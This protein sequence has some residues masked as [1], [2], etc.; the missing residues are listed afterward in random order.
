MK[1]LVALVLVLAPAIGIAGTPPPIDASLPVA[2]VAATTVEG[3]WQ[4]ALA[5]GST[6]L[7]LVV[8][9]RRTSA[10]WT[11]TLVSIDQGSRDVPI[12]VVKVDGDRVSLALSKVGARYEARLAGDKLTGTFTQSGAVLP[13]EL[14][15]TTNPSVAKPRPQEPHRPF[16]Y[17]EIEL[18]VDNPSAGLRLVSD[19]VAR[20]GK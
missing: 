13:L 11:G 4:G 8:N 20:H 5:I 10:G 18:G 15:K 19:W 2:A 12:D 7:R 9:I 16:L 3:A 6:R 1:A 14:E 17:D